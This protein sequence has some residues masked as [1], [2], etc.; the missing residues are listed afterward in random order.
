M[1]PMRIPT[2]D[3]RSLD[4]Y[5]SGPDDGTVLLFHVG[6]PGSG[7]PSARFLAAN[8]RGRLALFRSKNFSSSNV[9]TNHLIRRDRYRR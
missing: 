1:Q 2:P 8:D 5:V 3:G 6:T 9:L 4:T 7:T